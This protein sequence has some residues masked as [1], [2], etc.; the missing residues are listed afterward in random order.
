MQRR[1]ILGAGRQ[2]VVQADVAEHLPAHTVGHA[3]DD[4]GAVLRRV[5]V[6]PEGTLAE[7]GV[8]DP[9]DGARH[10]VGVS[11]LG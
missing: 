10:L 5:D 1:S 4:L 7:G 8:D 9:H 3:V 11:V 6:D 2:Q